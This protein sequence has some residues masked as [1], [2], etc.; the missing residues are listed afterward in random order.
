MS[1]PCPKIQGKL[2][3]IWVVIWLEVEALMAMMMIMV[4]HVSTTVRLSLL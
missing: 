4:I 3:R 1:K 2:V